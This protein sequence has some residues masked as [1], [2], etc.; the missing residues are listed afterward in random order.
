VVVDESFVSNSAVHN[1]ILVTA[2]IIT[3]QCNITEVSINT[4]KYT[5]IHGL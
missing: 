1:K 2:L 3:V 5:Q 4:S